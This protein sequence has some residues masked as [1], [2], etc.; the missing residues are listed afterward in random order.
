MGRFF[1][2]AEAAAKIGV[3]RQTLYSWIESALINAPKAIPV[4][5]AFIRLWT[6]ADID[7]AAKA[8]GKLKRGPK[9]KR[10]GGAK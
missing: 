7:L 5:G 1:T 3:S 9:P 4:G 8:K 10:K 2:T 6:K